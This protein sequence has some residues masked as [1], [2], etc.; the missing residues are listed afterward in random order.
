MDKFFVKH[1]WFILLITAVLI[2][3]SSVGIAGA[4]SAKPVELQPSFILMDGEREVGLVYALDDG[5]I[6]ADGNDLVYTCGCSSLECIE[7]II[8][9]DETPTP[10]PPPTT[11]PPPEPTEK[12]KC[13]R[14]IGNDSEGC[15][16]GNS[17][18]QGQGQG[19]DAGEDRNENKKDK[20]GK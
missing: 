11:P 18:G 16:P 9:G 17:S 13:N 19:R 6:L 15:D 2:V 3:L 14:G 4:Q 12:P 1:K 5:W 10:P 8:N 7:E 20:K